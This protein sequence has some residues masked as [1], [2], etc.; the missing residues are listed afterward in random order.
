MK[1]KNLPLKGSGILELLTAVTLLHGGFSAVHAADIFSRTN[2]PWDSDIWTTSA[3]APVQPGLRPGNSDKVFIYNTRTAIEVSTPVSIMGFKSLADGTVITIRGSE[4]QVEN[5][6]GQQGAGSGKFIVDEGVVKISG[7]Q[8]ILSG[9]IREKDIGTG[10]FE[11]SG[12]TVDVLSPNGLQLTSEKGDPNATGIYR[13]TGGVLNITG[14]G[15]S[16]AGI[17][18]GAGQGSFEWNGGTLNASSVG[19]DL[20]NAGS[21][22]LSP[23]GDDEV[24]STRLISET[25]Q[26]YTQ[27]ST[28][29]LTINIAGKKDFDQIV[30]QTAQSSAVQ[31]AAG[32][33]I[34]VKL[35]KNYQ[36]KAGEIFEIIIADNLTVKNIK[37]S[38]AAANRFSVKVDAN[39][40]SLVAR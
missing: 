28:A 37:L 12:G 3:G 23:G 14:A 18:K 34:E 2:G 40:V 8:C 31:L 6:L 9:H 21:G 26:T 38:G 16:T 22:N 24:G 19:V 10:E 30:W 13:L 29:R 20:N 1:V 17:A 4:F 35:L 27:G 39:S 33:T 11:Q 15:E 36:P 7:S 32:T 25:S 5:Y